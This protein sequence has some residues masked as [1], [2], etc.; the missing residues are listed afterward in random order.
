MF[1]IQRVFLFPKA[2]QCNK[3]VDFTSSKN[4][5]SDTT[6]FYSIAMSLYNVDNKDKS[7]TLP[8]SATS[9]ASQCKGTGVQVSTDNGRKSKSN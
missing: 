1:Q 7:L 4:S 9:K 6:K 8:L 2:I 5:I 3:A